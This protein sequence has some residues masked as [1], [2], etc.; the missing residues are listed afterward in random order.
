MNKSKPIVYQS[1]SIPGQQTATTG[2]SIDPVTRDFVTQT[3]PVTNLSVNP[4]AT[5]FNGNSIYNIIKQIGM[6]AEYSLLDVEKQIIML[7]PLQK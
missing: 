6:Q 3:I 4:Q 2:Q 5:S 1:L 7:P